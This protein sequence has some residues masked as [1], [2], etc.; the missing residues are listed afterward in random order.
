MYDPEWKVIRFTGT[1]MCTDE[2][3]Y[4]AWREAARRSP[5]G[6]AGF[7]TDCTP[8]YQQQMIA[9]D[10]CEH[11]WVKF[12][13]VEDIPTTAAILEENT[14]EAQIFEM[15]DRGI[16]GYIPIEVKHEHKHKR[17]FSF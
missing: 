13:M 14:L 1:P 10:R 2:A 6:D 4:E 16:T 12:K 8:N 3:T 11:H 5:P 15:S 9:N 7:C 17:R